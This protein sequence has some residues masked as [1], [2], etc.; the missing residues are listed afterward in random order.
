[1]SQTMP[2][3][4]LV[5]PPDR[6]NFLDRQTL[7]LPRPLTAA[8]AWSRLTARP[9][10]GLALA[11]RIRDAISARFGVERIGGLSGRPVGDPKAGEKLDFFLVER[12]EPGILTLSARDRHLETI[13]C[14]TT[15]ATEL[16]ITSSVLTKNRFGRLYMLPVAPAHRFIVRRQLKRLARELQAGA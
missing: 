15:S 7:V 11:F 3:P 4:D 12:A 14:V 6:L 13:T 8:E 9:L 2:A 10:P 16:A 5:A 1:M